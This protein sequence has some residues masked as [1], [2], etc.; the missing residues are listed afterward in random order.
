MANFKSLLKKV[1]Q[2]EIYKGVQLKQ[3]DFKKWQYGMKTFETKEQLKNFIDSFT[4]KK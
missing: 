1:M 4:T 3:V 2:P